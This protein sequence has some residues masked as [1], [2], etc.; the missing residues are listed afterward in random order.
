MKAIKG[1]SSSFPKFSPNGRRL[2][3]L[4]NG[5]NPSEL[6]AIYTCG[7]NPQLHLTVL[8]TWERRI[9]SPSGLQLMRNPAR[10]GEIKHWQVAPGD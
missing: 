10:H 5:E 9:H 6:V 7:L 8:K 3:G 2:N 1:N 4:L